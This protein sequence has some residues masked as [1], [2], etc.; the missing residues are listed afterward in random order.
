MDLGKGG[1]AALQ[2]VA[3]LPR[4]AAGASD[5]DRD[6]VLLQ[7]TRIRDDFTGYGY[8]YDNRDLDAVVDCFTA[9]CVVHGPRGEVNGADELRKKYVE[10]FAGWNM[11]RHVWANVLVRVVDP[12]REAYVCAYHHT[13][14]LGDPRSVCVTGTDIRRLRKVD[15][16]WKIAERWLTIDTE[17]ELAGTG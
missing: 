10:N 16:D 7:E 14:L 9:D 11:T 12:A 17:Y 5:A 13:L 3:R 15:G 6:A 4:W 8:V 1:V 2:D